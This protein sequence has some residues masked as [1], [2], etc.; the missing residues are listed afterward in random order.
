MKYIQESGFELAED[1][2]ILAKY[3]TQTNCGGIAQ[4][5]VSIEYT[6]NSK[7][8][9]LSSQAKIE[10]QDNDNIVAGYDMPE[11]LKSAIFFG[12]E[13]IYLKNT[14]SKGI[15][16][17]LIKALVHPIDANKLVFMYAGKIA[18]A[19]WYQLQLDS[20]RT[21]LTFNELYKISPQLFCSDYDE[22]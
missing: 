11:Y 5:Q 4:I 9:F 3:G 20:T 12:A 13:D 18:L 8:E 7:I 17:T 1:G 14:S 21:S 15:K 10:S 6:N 19:A 22:V 16:F 2:T